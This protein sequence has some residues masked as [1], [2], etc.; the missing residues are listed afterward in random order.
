M[1]QVFNFDFFD[2]KLDPRFITTT[3]MRYYNGV[4]GESLFLV[5]I[6]EWWQPALPEEAFAEVSQSYVYSQNNKNSF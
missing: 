5:I 6:L 4:V 2:E 1:G 3:Y